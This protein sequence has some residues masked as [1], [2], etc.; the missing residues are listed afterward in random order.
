MSLGRGRTEWHLRHGTLDEIDA[1]TVSLPVRYG[2]QPNDRVGFTGPCRVHAANTRSHAIRRQLLSLYPT[3]VRLISPLSKADPPC[4][5]GLD[6]RTTS[7]LL[8]PQVHRRF[9]HGSSFVASLLAFVCEPPQA[10]EIDAFW[11]A[12]TNA[13]P[14][15]VTLA[16]SFV[17]QES[18]QLRPLFPAERAADLRNALV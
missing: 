5:M 17:G 6:S 15:Q 11:P 13:V 4:S 9:Q 10:A 2:D 8:L 1:A 16:R 3:P 12:S 7:A 18:V 14:P